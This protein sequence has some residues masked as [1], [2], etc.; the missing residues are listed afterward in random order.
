LISDS[1]GLIAGNS[2]VVPGAI[3]I[4]DVVKPKA[5][6]ANTN[7]TVANNTAGGYSFAAKAQSQYVNSSGKY[8]LVYRKPF[9]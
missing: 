1:S 3:K 9:S 4:Y 5:P 7:K 8:N 6:V 2:L